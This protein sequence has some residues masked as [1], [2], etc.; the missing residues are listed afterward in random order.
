MGLRQRARMGVGIRVGVLRRRACGGEL[1]PPRAQA[2]FG[3]AMISVLSSH[4]RLL[5]LLLQLLL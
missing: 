2:G 1:L 4:T 3:V 5:L